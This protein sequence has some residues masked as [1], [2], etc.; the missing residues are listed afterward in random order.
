MKS[1]LVACAAALI[2]PVAVHAEI[3]DFTLSGKVTGHTMPNGNPGYESN[4]AALKAFL[5][6]YAL[7][8]TYRLTFSYDTAATPT[9]SYKGYAWYNSVPI[10]GTFALGDATAALPN[11][12]V[13]V[14][15]DTMMQ[16]ER[17]A[18]FGNAATPWMS[19]FGG[20][21][22]IDFSFEAT[23]ALPIGPTLPTN[24]T[25]AATPANYARVRFVRADVGE[26]G[27][28][29]S[30]DSLSRSGAAVPEPASWVMMIVG[31]GVAGIA[32]RRRRTPR[33]TA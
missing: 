3:G 19:Q 8:S 24:V 32:L 1:L 21:S 7:G 9:F 14:G 2:T 30:I 20:F 11:A 31:F 17:F 25:L 29:F 27:V 16:R 18:L 13:S 4:P 6:N 15:Y 5:A 10:G 33:A 23:S 26:T 12:S 28:L 22:P